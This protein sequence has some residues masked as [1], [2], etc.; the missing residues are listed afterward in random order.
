MRPLRDPVAGGWGES[1][2]RGL[3]GGGCGSW[4]DS[5]RRSG[6][7]LDARRRLGISRGLGGRRGGRCGVHRAS[8]RT[9]TQGAGSCRVGG[10]AGGG[11]VVAAAG[12]VDL[13]ARDGGQLLEAVGEPARWRAMRSDAVRSMPALLCTAWG[14]WMRGWVVALAVRYAR[15]KVVAIHQVMRSPQPPWPLDRSATYQLRQRLRTLSLCARVLVYS[16]GRRHQSELIGQA[17]KLIEFCAATRREVTPTAHDHEPTARALA[18]IL[19]V[20]HLTLALA[21]GLTQHRRWS[22]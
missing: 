18:L 12:G 7:A 6:V 5:G 21:E 20:Q 3:V 1:A 17:R 22:E 11:A 19:E 4:A 15:P 14:A 2:R 10:A 8:G 13:A 16:A 9:G